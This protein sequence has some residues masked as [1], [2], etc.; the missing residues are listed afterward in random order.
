MELHLTQN[1]SRR[2][3]TRRTP[4]A[5]YWW[6]FSDCDGELGRPASTCKDQTDRPRGENT[7]HFSTRGAT[8]DARRQ[9]QRDCVPGSPVQGHYVL[10]KSHATKLYTL[11][12][13]PISVDSIPISTSL[14]T[15][16]QYATRSF[17]PMF[18]FNPL[19]SASI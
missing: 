6:G 9:I 17:S 18:S 10:P 2:P 11:S 8:R 13:A 19:P 12:T 16:Y 4:R 15:P 5:S 1:V 14:V 7:K 3:R